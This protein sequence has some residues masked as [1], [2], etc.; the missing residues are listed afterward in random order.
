M[1]HEENINI[2]FSKSYYYHYYYYQLW[3]QANL[4]KTHAIS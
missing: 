3:A 4:D 1:R 2:K